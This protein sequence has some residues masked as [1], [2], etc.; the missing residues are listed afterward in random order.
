MSLLEFFAR[1]RNVYLGD[2]LSDGVKLV[3]TCKVQKVAATYSK[4]NRLKI[5]D[6]IIDANKTLFVTR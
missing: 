2:G 6:R 4:L 5:T 1:F 3:L